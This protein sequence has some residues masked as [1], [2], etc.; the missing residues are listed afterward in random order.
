MAGAARVPISD[1]L[2]CVACDPHW[3]AA[4][5]ATHERQLTEHRAFSREARKRDQERWRRLKASVDE[6]NSEAALSLIARA[7]ESEAALAR[8][9]HGDFNA[10]LTRVRDHHR[11]M[12]RVVRS[13]STSRHILQKE[14]AAES[15]ASAASAGG[16]ARRR[17]H[18]HHHDCV[19]DT[20]SA[21]DALLDLVDSGAPRRSKVD[22]EHS[23]EN[24]LHPHRMQQWQDQ[25]HSQHLAAIEAA[26]A[27]AAAAGGQGRAPRCAEPHGSVVGASLPPS[28]FPNVLFSARHVCIAP[29]SLA[30]SLA[31]PG[32]RAAQARVGNPE[33]LSWPP[34]AS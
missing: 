10:E 25:L 17:R 19:E 4:L 31:G 12:S 33:K 1:S 18:H 22:T 32:A 9:L 13:I 26:R 23:G 8:E 16:N 29:L 20:G 7:R 14:A 34:Y 11:K 21:V 30:L 6:D 3:Q 28:K 15:A 5:E 27:E 2:W 24:P